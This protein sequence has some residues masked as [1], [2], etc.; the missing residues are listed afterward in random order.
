MLA[1]TQSHAHTDT[2]CELS[3][4]PPPH[5]RSSHPG[6]GRSSGA[7]TGLVGR[8]V[9]PLLLAP[10]CLTSR[11]TGS[12]SKVQSHEGRPGVPRP[13]PA[14]PALKPAWQYLPHRQGP[15][16]G[17]HAQTLPVGLVREA[18]ASAGHLGEA[19]VSGAVPTP[20]L[21]SRLQ[22]PQ[23]VSG[24]GLGCPF[25]FISG[26]QARILWEAQAVW[27]WAGFS[28]AGTRGRRSRTILLA[29]T[30]A[31]KLC[32]QLLPQCLPGGGLRPRAP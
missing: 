10:R 23:P 20:A 31:P 32:V 16:A 12:P 30:A 11:T 1:H 8:A 3:E 21:A 14:H 19:V 13:H 25:T 9:G 26:A 18:S 15:G 24:W 29:P 4:P 27:G 5:P 7:G 17:P 28:G 2:P 6:R 22:G